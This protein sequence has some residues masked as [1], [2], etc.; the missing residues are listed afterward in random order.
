MRSIVVKHAEWQVYQTEANSGGMHH[1]PEKTFL[2]ERI[3]NIYAFKSP[4]L[5]PEPI[6]IHNEQFLSCYDCRIILLY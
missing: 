6:K 1:G 5:L 2:D 4:L 3:G